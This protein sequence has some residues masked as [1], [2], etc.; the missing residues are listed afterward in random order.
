MSCASQPKTESPTAPA[1]TSLSPEKNYVS[2]DLE[3]ARYKA[4]YEEL[5]KKTG[6][7]KSRGEAHITLITPPEFKAL[8]ATEGSKITAEQI[9]AEYKKSGLTAQDF[10]EICLAQGE[11]TIENKKMST[12]FIVVKSKVFL[13]FRQKLAK[14]SHLKKSA[15]NAKQFYPHITIGFTDRDL[16]FEDGLKKDIKKCMK[17]FKI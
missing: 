4:I 17:D 11:L 8:T 15:F 3:Y 10:K 12:Y 1:T 5:V 13:K 14:M 6:T 2:L 7:L 9:H 16:H